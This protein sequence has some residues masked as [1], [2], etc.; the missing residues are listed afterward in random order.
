MKINFSTFWFYASLSQCATI[1]F[2]EKYVGLDGPV[3]VVSSKDGDGL[4]QGCV[5][6]SDCND[7]SPEIMFRGSSSFRFKNGYSSDNPTS[8]V[9]EITGVPG[10]K[11]NDVRSWV[12]EKIRSFGENLNPSPEFR[13]I[14]I[15]QENCV[16]KK[17]CNLNSCNKNFNGVVI[18]YTFENPNQFIN[19]DGGCTDCKPNRI[20]ET[21][22]PL[23]FVDIPTTVE[24]K[25]CVVVKKYR[26][27][28]CDSE[29]D[30]DQKNCPKPCN[31]CQGEISD[32]GCL[33]VIPGTETPHIVHPEIPVNP[34]PKI[35][36]VVPSTK[37]QL[38]SPIKPQVELQ[39]VCPTVIKPNTCVYHQNS[40]EGKY[41]IEGLMMQRKLF[42]F[43][44]KARSLLDSLN[45]I[46]SY[47]SNWSCGIDDM[48]LVSLSNS[49]V[50]FHQ[51]YINV[52]GLDV[53]NTPTLAE[54]LKREVDDFYG[55]IE[56]SCRN[57]G[58]NFESRLFID[59]TNLTID[60]IKKTLKA[61]NQEKL[62]N[63]FDFL[64]NLV[65]ST[66]EKN[67]AS[68][69][70]NIYYT[71]NQPMVQEELSSN[72]FN[73]EIR[74]G[75]LKG[76]EIDKAPQS[77]FQSGGSS[78]KAQKVRNYALDGSGNQGVIS[79]KVE[80]V[81]IEGAFDLTDV[82]SSNKRC[83][84]ILE[85]EE[86]G[87]ESINIYSQPRKTDESNKSNINSVGH[88]KGNSPR[89]VS[90]DRRSEAN[91]N[92]NR[93]ELDEE[94]LQYMRAL[95]NDKDWTFSSLKKTR[96]GVDLK[97][98]LLQNQASSNL[99]EL[100]SITIGSHNNQ[101]PPDNKIY[102]PVEID[103]LIQNIKNEEK[104]S[105]KFVKYNKEENK[106]DNKE[107]RIYNGDMVD[108]TTFE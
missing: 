62:K 46:E 78:H 70:P 52:R 73:K 57:L 79:D 1:S 14:C 94:F 56:K 16:Q 4:I 107:I 67:E 51:A 7:F 89:I 98:N 6:G 71:W 84:N 30:N 22:S 99:E 13:V 18:N 61:I 85:N 55:L 102:Q 44:L 93:I 32:F 75:E 103:S 63:I 66:G 10:F 82:N 15:G 40:F 86:I 76:I 90:F 80:C 54:A 48:A 72:Q 106:E 91:D 20:M 96:K 8:N 47:S 17:I 45:F 43:Y 33:F 50:G 38:V 49:I 104:L 11:I 83:N 41:T 108:D 5:S 77:G 37:P 74:K 95:I 34:N 24:G 64:G 60:N 27:G 68:K 23:V 42:D 35:T 58:F 88:R 69:Y 19:L 87:K 26:V 28:R 21:L 25:M 65:E 81:N 101:S 100:S 2:S 97:D 36:K 53:F 29:C 92:R 31:S 39:N 59:I 105:L 12:E 9:Y 3:H